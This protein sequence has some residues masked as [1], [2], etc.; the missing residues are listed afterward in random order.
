MHNVPRGK[1][2]GAWLSRLFPTVNRVDVR[3]GWLEWGVNPAPAPAQTPAPVSPALSAF[4]RGIERRAFVFAQVQCGRDDDAEAALGRSMR[5][6]RK[7]SA[8]SP[9]SSWPAGFWALLLAQD[10]LSEGD[11]G[12]PELSALSSGPRAALLLRL[13]AGLDFAHAAQVLGV[14]EDTYRFA[15]QRALQQMGTAGVSYAQLGALRER[16]HRQVK[17]LPD[18]RIAALSELRGRVLQGEPDPP[19]PAP[20]PPSRLLP[21]VL[22]ALLA[23]LALVF[24][25]TF[26][27]PAPTLAPGSTEGLPL[28]RAAIPVPGSTDSD[29]VTH[30][31]YAQLAAPED[32]GLAADLALLSW[33]ASGEAVLPTPEAAAD[34]PAAT[35]SGTAGPDTG[36]AAPTLDPATP[37][38]ATKPDA[39]GTEAVQPAPELPDAT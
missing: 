14:S 18:A 6:F 5:A 2:H 12:V 16:L 31:D 35:A 17:T 20:L 22:W 4:L 32:E 33:V 39:A 10:E 24:A 1:P 36:K 3:P 34:A 9:L 13:V 8:L 27:T 29:R 28:E 11:S 19:P 30:P 15:L 26:W 37:G 7:L 25:A 21:R 38:Q 23:L